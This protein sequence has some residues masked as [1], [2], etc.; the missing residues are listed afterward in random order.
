MSGNTTRTVIILL[1]LATAIVHG[2]LLN[3][4]GF[5]VLF[6]LNALGYLAL[7]G[8]FVFK[9]PPGREVLVHYA[10]MAYAAVTIVAWAVMNGDRGPLGYSTKLIEML[11]IIFLWI[12]LGRVR[13]ASK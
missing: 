7:L 3:L 4:G 10:L 2:V 9:F 5:S 13:A 12:D 8:A 11:L 6:T 1:T